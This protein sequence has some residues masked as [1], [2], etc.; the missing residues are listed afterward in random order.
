MAP[1]DKTASAETW[2]F[3]G[4]EAYKAGKYDDA[5]V[6]FARSLSNDP[7]QFRALV[8]QGLAHFELGHVDEARR[9]LEAAIQIAPQYAKAHN[10][11]GNVYRRQ[12]DM[13]LA[14]RSFRRAAELDPRSPEYPYNVGITLLD[15]NHVP[16]AIDAL[17]EAYR[18]APGD[19]EIVSELA[20]AYVRHRAIADAAQLLDAFVSRTPD[21]ERAA[22]MRARIAHLKHLG[23]DGAPPAPTSDR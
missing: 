14:V 10:A 6:A 13:D 7:R 23:T 15:V 4:A 5:L 21:H 1:L 16:E 12:G 19:A 22:E 9:A 17:K 2:Y 8:F 20:G 3:Q 11:L 18:C